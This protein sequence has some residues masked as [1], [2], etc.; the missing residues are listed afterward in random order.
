MISNEIL[1]K[2]RSGKDRQGTAAI[3]QNLGYEVSRNYKFRLRKDEKTPSASIRSDGYIVD[4]GGDFRGDIIDLL[5][6]QFGLSFQLAAEY[7][8]VCMGVEYD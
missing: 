8:A 7:V 4:F 3:L 5:M 1:Q 6:G 2:I